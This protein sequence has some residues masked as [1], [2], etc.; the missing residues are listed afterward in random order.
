MYPGSILKTGLEIAKGKYISVIDGDGQFPISSIIKSYNII[1]TKDVDFVKTYRSTRGD[2][3]NRKAVSVVYNTFF[4][5]LFPGLKSNDINSKPK[6]IR[7]EVLQRMKLQSN[8]WFIDAEI[9]IAVRRFKITFEEFPVE[10][11]KQENRL[12]FVKFEAILEFV[13]NLIIYR[14][15]EFFKTSK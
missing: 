14:W 3:F 1:S 6:T 7:K 10:F 15:K 13:K 12:S 11:Y 5:L 2:G 4:N 8:D 9:M